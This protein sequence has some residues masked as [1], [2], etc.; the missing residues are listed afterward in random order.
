MFKRVIVKNIIE[1]QNK[2]IKLIYEE[3]RK[4]F[5]KGFYTYHHDIFNENDVYIY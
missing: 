3:K 5:E 2:T 4:V 1:R